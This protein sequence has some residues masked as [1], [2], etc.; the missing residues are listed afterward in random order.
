MESRRGDSVSE[1]AFIIAY[2][3]PSTLKS[4]VNTQL[5]FRFISIHHAQSELP[6]FRIVFHDLD[7]LLL[8]AILN[9]CEQRKSAFDI[10]RVPWI[11]LSNSTLQWLYWGRLRRIPSF[12]QF[13]LLTLVV[14]GNHMEG[15]P[16]LLR[17]A[18]DW[19][20]SVFSW[21]IIPITR[22]V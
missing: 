3:V 16:L 7:L 5:C 21:F 9:V 13:V 6:R 17:R 2:S 15:R 10:R 19:L 14:A 1:N 18:L 22:F 20:A 12:S 11:P 4:I 8:R